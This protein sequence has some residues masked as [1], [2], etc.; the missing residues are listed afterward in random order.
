MASHASQRLSRALGPSRVCC[1]CPMP[2]LVVCAPSHNCIAL[3][4]CFQGITA[5]S[6][7]C[8]TCAEACTSKLLPHHY[9]MRLPYPCT[10]SSEATTFYTSCLISRIS[11]EQHK[12]AGMHSQKYTAH[13]LSLGRHDTQEGIPKATLYTPCLSMATASPSRPRRME[14]LSCT[15]SAIASLPA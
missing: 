15:Y 3:A 13:L 7:I 11:L 1:Y 2:S 9:H 12:L 5:G 6:I 4:S 8:S 14:S 10:A